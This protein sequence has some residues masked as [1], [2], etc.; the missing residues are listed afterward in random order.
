MEDGQLSTVNYLLSIINVYCRQ[1]IPLLTKELIIKNLQGNH[2]DFIDLLFTMSEKD[3]N[4]SVNN[5]WTAGQHFEHIYISIS[6][7]T[8]ALKLPLFFLKI[9]FGKANRP[10]KDYD[11]LVN[12]YHDKL[13][14]GG[15]ASGRYIPKQIS[16]KQREQLK[17]KLSGTVLQLCNTI[18]NCTESSL[19]NY[20]LPHPLLG[21]L[22]IR[23]MLYFTI[24]HV[25]H[26]RNLVNKISSDHKII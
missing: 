23:E 26:H 1:R 19:D 14:N 24:Y 25:E 21:K 15:V 5:K 9:I 17:R 8:R 2:Q 11:A 10:S 7:L 22:T 4:L 3:F 13:E 18:E 6:A 12:K 20:I 16:F